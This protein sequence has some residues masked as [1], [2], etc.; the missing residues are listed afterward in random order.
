MYTKFEEH[1]EISRTSG[2]YND[3]GFLEVP[4]FT[5]KL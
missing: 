2:V 4:G 5:R 1:V 3:V